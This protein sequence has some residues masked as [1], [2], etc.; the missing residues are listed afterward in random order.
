MDLD[1]LLIQTTLM[2]ATQTVD[3]REAVSSLAATLTS[4]VLGDVLNVNIDNAMSAASAACR[5]H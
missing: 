2:L 5:T 4:A 3:G 1:S